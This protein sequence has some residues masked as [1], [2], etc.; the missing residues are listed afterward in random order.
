[1]DDLKLYAK[2]HKELEGLLFTVKQFNDDI[3]M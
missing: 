3:D 2:N 1:M